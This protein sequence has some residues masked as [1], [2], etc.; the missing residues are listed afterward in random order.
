MFTLGFG[1]CLFLPELAAVAVVVVVVVLEPT[2][3]QTA[4]CTVRLKTISTLSKRAV[5]A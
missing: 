1:G 4:V 3:Y 2:V 5:K